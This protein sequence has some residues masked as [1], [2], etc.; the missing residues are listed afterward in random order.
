MFVLSLSTKLHT[1]NHVNVLLDKNFIVI[2][3]QFPFSNFHFHVHTNNSSCDHLLV[4]RMLDAS[5]TFLLG[6]C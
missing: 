5:N 2:D 6:V 3:S 1:G 4:K